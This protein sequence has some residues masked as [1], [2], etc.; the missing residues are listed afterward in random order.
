MIFDGYILPPPTLRFDSAIPS[1]VSDQPFK[2]IRLHGPF[3]AS[4][5]TL[6]K[7]SILFVFPENER[8]LSRRL[9]VALRDGYKGF[10]GFGDMFRVAFS[11]EHIVTL[12]IELDRASPVSAAAAYREA[13]RAW[14]A[15]PRETDPDLALVLVPHS[16]RWETDRPYYEAKAAFA[17]LGIPTQ[18]V[19]AELMQNERE[20]GWSVAN[21]ALATFAKLGGVPWTVDAPANEK[22]LILGVGRADIRRDGDTKRIFGYALSFNSNGSYRHTWSFTPAADEDSYSSRLEDAVVAALETD[23]PVDDPPE[24]LVV[25]L[26]RRT[27]QREIFAVSQAMVRAGKTLPVLIVRLDDSSLYDVADAGT[28]HFAPSKGLAVQIAASRMLL[29]TEAASALGVPDGPLLIELDRRSAG[30]SELIHSVTA[31][32]FRLAHANWRGFNARSSPVTLAYGE[33]LAKLVGYLEE[34]D[35]WDPSLLRSELRDRPWFL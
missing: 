30:S 3:D 31:Q 6:R 2:G 24:R 13:I 10:P 21:I 1:R 28:D 22:D 23:M 29:Q 7:G 25:H 12:P 19:T 15:E 16:E 4:R 20:F 26:G 18:M 32:A 8:E 17:Q 35:T 34:V 9:G 14:N 27:G 11:N 5:V 33:L